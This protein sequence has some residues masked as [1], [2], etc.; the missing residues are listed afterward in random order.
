MQADTSLFPS[1]RRCP[2]GRQGS[3]LQYSCLVPETSVHFL[4]WENSPGEKIDYPLQY[5]WASLVAQTVKNLPALSG[6]NPWVGKIPWRRARQP[7]P[8]FLPG[9]SPCTEEPGGVQSIELQRAGHDWSNWACMH[10]V[11][12]KVLITEFSLKKQQLLFIGLFK[13]STSVLNFDNFPLCL[14][15]I[16]FL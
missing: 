12:C 13:I 3:P 10:M 4:G 6:F 2:G 8:V 14:E 16:Y 11:S 1:L 5:S 15:S 9:D 7:T